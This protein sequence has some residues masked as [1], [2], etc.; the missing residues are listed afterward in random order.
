MQTHD[1][2]V[3]GNS[4]KPPASN[5]VPLDQ[6]REELGKTPA[7]IWRWRQRG[8]IDVQ[9]ICGRLYISR[10]E[11]A[12]FEIRVAAGEFSRAHKTTNRKEVAY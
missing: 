5:I 7:T 11:I 2:T 3:H 4:L 1:L 8:W 9:N 6:W 10:A 12:R